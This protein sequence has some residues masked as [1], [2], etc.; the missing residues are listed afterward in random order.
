MR[1]PGSRWRRRR[2]T[3]SAD[4]RGECPLPL[5]DE[6]RERE[7]RE[8]DGDA[9]GHRQREQYPFDVHFRSF[10]C[11]PIAFIPWMWPRSEAIAVPL[12]FANVLDPLAPSLRFEG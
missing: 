1:A 10:Q 5:P 6:P 7:R 2:T 9:R 11:R 3:W 12:A 4:A 8:E